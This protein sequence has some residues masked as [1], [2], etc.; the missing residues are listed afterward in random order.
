MALN[1][2]QKIIRRSWDVIPMPDTV[3]ARV[4]TLGRDQ[5][6]QLIFTDR[7]GRLIGDTDDAEIPGV[8]DSDED[9]DAE[10]P[11][12]DIV[13]LPGVDVAD[14]ET[15]NA[16]Q[17]VEI[18]DLDIPAPDPQPVAADTVEQAQTQAAPVEPAPVAQPAGVR[19]STRIKKQTKAYAPSMSGS[20]YSY[21]VTQL[22]SHG[23]L[24]PDA[25]MFVQ[26]DFYQA[27]PDVVAAI[28][29]QLSLKSGLKEWGDK[30]YTAVESEMKQLHFRN[31]FKP[32]HW[33]KLT[34][35]QR[36]TVLESHMFLKEKRDGKIKGRTVAGG[37]KQR[38]YIS[39]EDASS[40]TV[41][42][43]SVLLS[44]IIDAEEERDVAVID[45]PNA[46]VQ[47]RVE[48]EK[49]MA[50]IKLRGV[51]VDIL[52]EIAPDVYKPY[53]TTDKKG[54]RQLLVQCQN[55][56]YGTMVAS[57]LY[58]RKFTKS[59]TG[60]GFE[61]N[62]YDPCVA[63]K[64]IEGKQMTICFHVDD[65][66]L[67]HRKPKVMDKMIE[68][69]RQE[70]ESIFEDGSGQ[71][72]VSRGKVHKYLGMTLDYTI[73][74]Q[75]MITM[76]DYIEEILT[77]FD[78]ADPKGGGTKTSAASENL[79][80]IDEDCE[81]LQPDKAVEFHNLVAKTLYATKRARPDTCTAIAFLTTRV[82]APDK[83]DWTKLVHLMKYLRGTRTLPLILSANK[84]GILKWWVDASFAVHPNMRGH[85]GG[86]LS[87]GRGFP[88]VSSTKQKLNTRSSTETEIVGADDFMPAICW[89]RYFME[90]QGYQVK[91][92]VLFQ[93]N[94]SAILLEKN[95]KASSSKR[96]KH[97]N[98]RY[99]FI[100]DRVNKGDV[101]LVWCPTG[102]M[103][104]D[105]MTKPLQ[106]ALFRKFR[107]QIMGVIPAR[108]PGPGKA[109]PGNGESDT[110]KIKPRKGKTVK[111]K[112]GAPGKGRH[113][114]SVLG[115]VSKRT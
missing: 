37:N 47:T 85:S 99:F 48:D 84:S 86:G 17:I 3:I 97:I 49:D 20:R 56:L 52:V 2:G 38:D 9:D 58:Y 32:M 114:R 16:P 31:T 44:C 74:G 67:S 100:T 108:D 35:I 40:P 33:K 102:D 64:I 93:D 13:E 92:N 57:L 61:L 111:E 63:N 29:T 34:D 18:D 22:E 28:M 68:W 98:I 8:V 79:F 19:R 62:P 39:K 12:V 112:F 25:H 66:K 109:K 115:V 4:N 59:L 65:C 81:K 1:T 6:E 103:I 70:Y 10:I 41:A 104:G 7:L 5:P 15:D 27:E 95:G 82:R 42:T 24:N 113:H 106:G 21:A 71:M 53:A 101:S 23:V 26:E 89:T 80:R 73:R 46:F 77:A 88:I 55:A 107:D 78:K 14:V 50:I 110:H 83:D 11:G 75:V 60:I 105:F 54:V 30:A 43:E 45:I 76:N 96:T 91:D 72:T 87:L 69:L 36:Q 51:L 90:A 94:K